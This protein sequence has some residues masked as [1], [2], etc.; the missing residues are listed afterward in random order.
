MIRVLVV[1]DSAF[2]RVLLTEILESS[3]NI[4]VV[5]TAED[6]IDAREKIKKYDPDVIT[7]DIEMPKMDGITFLKNIMR[8]RPMPVIMV[9]TLTQ[10][11]ADIT[12]EALEYGAFDFIGKPTSDVKNRLTNLADDLVNKVIAAAQCNKIALE[13]RDYAGYKSLN[14]DKDYPHDLIAIGASTGGTEAI[15]EIIT[16]LPT[17]LPPI[18]MSQHIPPNFSKSF[19]KRLNLQ[20]TI[21]VR[22]VMSSTRLEYGFAYLAPGS[23]HLII[24]KRNGHFWAELD[25]GE[26]V[27]RHKPSV[28][29]MFNSIVNSNI[30]NCLGIVLTGMG[31]D[32][33]TG[34]KALKDIGASTL[35]QDEETSVVWG[36]PGASVKEGGVD[37]IL[38][39][40]EIAQAIVSSK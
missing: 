6:P 7:L 4:Q 24:T 12:L 2:I 17:G 30:E 28:D 20:S 26:K 23:H 39:L 32:G 36:M 21:N 22:E 27:N 34:L 38:P 33:A 10:V 15:R 13:K 40:G 5:A 8:L 35:V 3:K 16:Q 37:R 14:I 18:V 1:D 25:D 29:V 11:G 31:K 19:A 9:S